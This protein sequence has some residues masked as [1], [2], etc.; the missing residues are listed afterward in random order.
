MI[1]IELTPILEDKLSEEAMK[2]GKLTEVTRAKGMVVADP[3]V[4]T[5]KLN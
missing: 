2:L 1:N 4:P 5:D 3:F